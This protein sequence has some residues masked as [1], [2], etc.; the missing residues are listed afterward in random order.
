M[1]ATDQDIDDLTAGDSPR[2]VF[3]VTDSAGVAVD[4]TGMT[5]RWVLA[6]TRGAT[7]VIDKTSGGGGVVITD[8]VNGRLRVEL[9]P[10][11]TEPL[12]G[13][14]FH[15]LELTDS[16]GIVSTAAQGWIY[17]GPDTA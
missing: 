17:I 4:L 2:L 12:R 14:Y 15:E 6:P 16:T 10:T 5:A 7:P 9:S 11:E 13:R 3:P 8:A 1:T